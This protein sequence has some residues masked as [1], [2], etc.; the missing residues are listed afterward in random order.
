M[1]KISVVGLGKLGLCFAACA[2]ARGFKTVGVDIDANVVNSVNKGFSP[3]IEP[4]LQKLI[5][6]VGDRLT[7]TKSHE[8]AIEKTD[9]TFIMVA[10]PSDPDGNFSNK[11]VESALK[12]LAEA[13]RKSNKKYHLFV[14]SSTLMPTSTEE[15]LIPL[16]QEH[17]GKKLNV[18]FGVCYNPDFVALGNVIKDFLNPDLVV[19]GESNKF[20]GEQLACTYE[21]LCENQPPIFRMSIINA[22]IAKVS[23][24][25]YITLKISFANTLANI[26][27]RIPGADVDIITKTL[28]ADRRISPYYLR[29]GL[30]YGGTCFPRDTKAFIA[31]TKKYGYETELIKA[32]EKVNKF[33]GQHL[34]EKVLTHISCADE[35]SISILGL[36]FKPNTPV[37]TGSPAIK[38]INKLLKENIRIIVYDPLAMENVK[39]V[40][41]DKVLYANSVRNCILQ[42]SVCVITTQADE[43]KSIDESYI[44]HNPTTIIDCWRILDPT[45]LGKSRKVRY[46]AL[47]EH[48]DEH[49]R[50]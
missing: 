13:F 39:A 35:R 17:S 6:K 33:Q 9:V 16:I 42:S 44:V 50:I 1:E 10:T 48:K 32:V 40:L 47:G 20:A 38:L 36:S 5:S 41:G 7:A 8:E 15:R 46:I 12:S 3:I 30:S 28:G 4:G 23:L 43:F 31:F 19:I 49:H 14:I 37:I 25:S 34:A 45:K 27:E 18:D 26:C 29:G 21:R 11:Y 2:A 22:E 24:N